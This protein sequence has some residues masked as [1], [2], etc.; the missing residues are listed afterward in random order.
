MKRNQ[1]STSLAFF[2]LSLDHHEMTWNIDM[3]IIR[4]VIFSDA[5][6]NFYINSFFDSDTW[7]LMQS[8]NGVNL[9]RKS[10][11]IPLTINSVLSFVFW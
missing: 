2:L 3:K 6:L 9:G 1:L 10:T 5:T 7:T 4:F 11:R 8:S